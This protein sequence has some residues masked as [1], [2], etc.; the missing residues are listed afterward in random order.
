MTKI[1]FRNTM[2][3]KELICEKGEDVFIN[4]KA[5]ITPHKDDVVIR[6]C[7][8]D[9]LKA[10]YWSKEKGHRNIKLP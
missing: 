8:N 5:M 10:Y 2:T 4:G 3:T 7:F 1:I 6:Y 9:E